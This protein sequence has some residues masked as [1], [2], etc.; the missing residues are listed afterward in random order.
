MCLSTKINNSF[1]AITFRFNRKWCYILPILFVF[2]FT[3]SV[4]SDVIIHCSADNKN[5]LKSLANEQQWRI[6]FPFES[7][8][9]KI[10]SKQESFLSSPQLNAFN[11]LLLYAIISIPD[12]NNS[13]QLLRQSGLCDYIGDNHHYS[14]DNDDIPNDSLWGSQWFMDR[15]GLPEAWGISRGDNVLVA[16]IDTGCGRTSSKKLLLLI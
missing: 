6:S 11:A 10:I 15:I 5:N 12:T 1:C 14:L 7:L 8:S 9:K 3:K 13:K 4:A 16:V 2:F